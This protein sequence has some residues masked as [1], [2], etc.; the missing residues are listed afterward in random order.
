M[1]DCLQDAGFDVVLNA[2]SGFG[3]R[4]EIPAL[5]DEQTEDLFDDSRRVCEETLIAEGKMRP[6]TLPT[7]ED[8]RTQYLYL[9]GARECLI[10]L[11]Y[12]IQLPPSEGQY[13]SE[14]GTWQ[15]HNELELQV[16]D[17][18]ELESAYAACPQIPTPP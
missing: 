13:I 14:G 7:T 3:P 10:S 6:T 16:K 1:R 9:I 12:E 15:P 18:E 2:D 8:L 11:D 4:I 5:P 17:F